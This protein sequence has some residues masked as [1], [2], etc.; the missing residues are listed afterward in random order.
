L[1]E[2]LIE[3]W[4]TSSNE[5]AYQIP[6]C[7]ALLAHGFR[8]IH[9]SRHGRGEHGKDIVARDS[10]GTLMTFQLKGGDLTLNGW[11][12]IRGEVEELV[13]LPVMLPGAISQEPHQ[14]V[15]VT[16][17]ELRGDAVQNIREFAGVW[18]SQ[19]HG[20][21]TVWQKTEVLERFVSAHGHYV[22]SGLTNFRTFVE[23]FVADFAERLPRRKFSD[24]VLALYPTADTTLQ[25]KR[26]LESAVLTG[27]YIVGQYAA[28]ANHVAALE[29]W[30]ILAAL[31]L[32]AVE[33]DDLPE[34]TYGPTLQLIREG[35]ERSANS[36]T[37]EVMDSRHFLSHALML[38][39]DAELRSTRTMLVL[40]WL[41]ALWLRGR[42]IGDQAMSLRSVGGVLRREFHSVRVIGEADWPYFVSILYLVEKDSTGPTADRLLMKWIDGV[43]ERNSGEGA[44]MPSPYWL[45]EKILARVYGTLA[46]GDDESF[47]GHTY[48]VHSALDMLVRRLCRQAVSRYWRPVSRLTFCDF[49]PDRPADWF[50]WR[51]TDGDSRM[52]HYP[53]AVSWRQWR[54][55]ADSVRRDVVPASLLRHVEWLL[56][57]ALVFPHRVNR[58]LTATID[59]VFGHRA[60]L[61]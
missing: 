8:V 14:P 23:L 31:V 12:E 15:L 61:S 55:E 32:H 4:L 51:C 25:R 24:F 37:A 42:A 56:P 36:F 43:L 9:V 33:R 40:G 29:G 11:R 48:T 35:F 45:Q 21:L 28:A 30:T 3:H 5:K 41:C 52:M 7:E 53:L 57:F 60:N 26:A 47:R 44:G 49:E 27:Q 20:L 17:G 50:R 19:G 18:H 1:H 22:P 39:E 38:A 46:P 16:N 59:A 10:A 58:N 2:K 13:K 54:K 6:F 34:E